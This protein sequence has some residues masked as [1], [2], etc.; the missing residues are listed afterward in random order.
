M[1]MF[2]TNVNEIELCVTEHVLA[3]GLVR[4]DFKCLRL[5]VVVTNPQQTNV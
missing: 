5:E 4:N 3:V 2:H 1:E